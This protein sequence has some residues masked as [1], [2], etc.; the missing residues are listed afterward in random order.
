MSVQLPKEL[1]GTILP[2]GQRKKPSLRDVLSDKDLAAL[3]DSYLNFLYSVSLSSKLG[4]PAGDKIKGSI[5]ST[6]LKE[7]GLREVLPKRMDRHDQAD[8]LEALAAYT[9]IEELLSFRRALKIL[10]LYEDLT[11]G[12]IELA[13]KMREVFERHQRENFIPQE[14]RKTMN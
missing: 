8:A 9:W 14:E 11:K 13:L 6:A 2:T 3:G 12:M 10:C 4:R 1:E 7:S 5:L